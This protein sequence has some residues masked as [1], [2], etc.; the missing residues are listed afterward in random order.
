MSVQKSPPSELQKPNENDTRWL[1]RKVWD[2]VN[3]DNEHFMGLIIGREGSGKSYTAIKI[4]DKLDPTFDADRIIFDV[5]ELLEVLTE[6]KHEPGN[7]YV[8]DEAGVQ[9]GNRTWQERS[10]VLANQALQLIRSHNLGLIFT[11]PRVRELD[12]QAYARQQA[13]LEM[14]EKETDEYV[15][16]KWQWV[17]PDRRRRDGNIYLHNPRRGPINGQI[18]EVKSIGFKPPTNDELIEEYEERK[19]KFQQEFYE[20]TIREAR[21]ETEEEEDDSMSPRELA[22]EIANGSV[23]R[24]V[25]QHNQTKQPYINGDLIRSYYDVSHSDA[26]AIKSMLEQQYDTEELDQ[27]V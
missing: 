14:V 8:L 5:I 4:A 22:T 16:A 17:D 25:S 11:L 18:R 2:R 3:R 21:G 27:Y 19:S 12:E 6:G 7:F 15:R 23:E 10:Q 24:F 1:L 13:Q 26:R 20:R 9:M